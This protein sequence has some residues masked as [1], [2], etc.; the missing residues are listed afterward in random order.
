MAGFLCQPKNMQICELYPVKLSTCVSLRFSTD[1]GQCWHVHKFTQTPMFFTGLAS[2]P[3]ARSVNVSLWGYED[4]LISH[5]VTYTIDFKDL[6]TRNC[7]WPVLFEPHK[8]KGM[9]HLYN[10]VEHKLI[11]LSASQARTAITS[12]GWHTLMTSA[13]Q[14][15]VAC[16]VIRNVSC[17][18]E[19]TLCVGLAEIT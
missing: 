18:W 12:S 1:E 3:G 13:T 10:S 8:I 15:M 2:E 6:L 16:W 7:E 4:A 11:F 17:V 14:K 5:W 9:L 19:R